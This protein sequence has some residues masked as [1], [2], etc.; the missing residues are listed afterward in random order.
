MYIILSRNET[1]K[2][3]QGRQNQLDLPLESRSSLGLIHLC[4]ASQ[5]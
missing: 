4:A 2:L 1:H 5:G 3:Q